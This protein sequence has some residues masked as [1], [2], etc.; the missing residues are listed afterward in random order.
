VTSKREQGEFQTKSQAVIR[1]ASSDFYYTAILLCMPVY[2]ITCVLLV[3]NISYESVDTLFSQFSTP[4]DKSSHS[5]FN[6]DQ[7]AWVKG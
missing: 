5:Q 6:Q 3:A 2:L 4:L 7:K 1:N